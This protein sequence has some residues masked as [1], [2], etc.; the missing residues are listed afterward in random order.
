MVVVPLIVVVA[1]MFFVGYWVGQG[2]ARFRLQETVDLVARGQVQTARAEAAL[3]ERRAGRRLT[4]IN[5]LL[6]VI[7]GVK[8]QSSQDWVT[9]A[10]RELDQSLQDASN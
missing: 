10:H 2:A 6:E 5:G 3:Q 1:A 7:E 9:E 8:D 4:I